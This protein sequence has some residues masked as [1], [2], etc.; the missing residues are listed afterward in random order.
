MVMTTRA[1]RLNTWFGLLLWV[2]CIVACDE[3]TYT[4]DFNDPID[5][6]SEIGQPSQTDEQNP[7]Q[8]EPAADEPIVLREQDG[9]TI[10]GK[11]ISAK[12][13][14]QLHDCKNITIIDCD[15]TQVI[16]DGCTGLR[17]VNC[18]LHDTDGEAVYLDNC[19]DVLIQGNR[20]ERVKSGVLAHQSTAIRV[21]G[22]FCKDVLGP[23][24][25]G[26]LVQFDKVTGTGNAITDNYALNTLGLSNPEDVI[27]LYQSHGTE[28]SPILVEN[29]YLLGDPIQG[30][31]GKSISGSGIMLGD[32][33]GSWQHCRNNTLISP[34][35]V[36][37]G[38]A[39][40]ENIVGEENLVLGRRSDVSNVGLYAW[41]QYVDEP[42]GKIT[43]RKNT[44]AW[45]NNEGMDNPYWDGG[46]FTKVIEQD[47]RFGGSELLEEISKPRPPSIAPQ[48]L[49]PFVEE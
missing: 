45:V 32:N 30:S 44:V 6:P 37:I 26:Q 11:T 48:P 9:L 49:V 5:P 29:N 18:Y 22:N 14:I 27:N 1:R 36:G 8:D 7:S 24:P 4:P 13:A 15:L 41:N 43:F 16:A 3:Q 33:G 23:L 20:I 31:R 19:K 40:G 2:G 38:V 39:C 34:G 12:V 10:R 17:I 35:Q 46:G 25:G 28:E 47:N 21:V 42:A